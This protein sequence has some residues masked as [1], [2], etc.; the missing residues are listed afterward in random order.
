MPNVGRLLTRLGRIVA[1]PVVVP[2]R[3]A[4]RAAEKTMQ[5]MILGVIR[6]LLTWGG[7]FLWAGDDLAQFVAA[8]ATIV[9]LVWSVVEKRKR[10]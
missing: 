8:A 5:A 4:K 6:H 3:A 10:P 7:G 2:I 9:G 1:A